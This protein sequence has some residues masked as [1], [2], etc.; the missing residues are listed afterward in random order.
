MLEPLQTEYKEVCQS[1]RA[2]TDFRAKL[3]ALL[4]IASGTGIF[5]L[6]KE[7]D[8]ALITRHLPAIGLF[9]FLATL[10]LFFYELH[11]MDQCWD[12][13][14]RGKLLEDQL[15]LSGGQLGV[16]YDKENKKRWFHRIIGPEGAA[17]I[18][19]LTMMFTWLYI[20]AFGF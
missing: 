12:L 2:V 14:Q 16:Q 10:G 18:I 20:A 15:G 13:I 6:L 1:H 7:G 19:Y 9:G 3:L 5:L 11:A 4:P 8:N 17:W